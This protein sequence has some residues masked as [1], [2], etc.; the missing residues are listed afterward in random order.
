M[1]PTH[2]IAVFLR[3]FSIWL[4]L[5]ALTFLWMLMNPADASVAKAIW[6]LPAILIIVS[7]I[8]WNFPITIS[9]ILIPNVQNENLISVVEPEKLIRGG[10]VILGLIL[11]SNGISSLFAFILSYQYTMDGILNLDLKFK[12][13]K[14]LIDGLIGILLILKNSVFLRVLR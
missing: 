5:Y 10:I 9:K 7:L 11:L 8:I 1:K 4:I 12:M 3:L 13:S 6:P 14:S 2:I